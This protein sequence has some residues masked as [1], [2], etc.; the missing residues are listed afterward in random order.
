MAFVGPFGLIIFRH[1]I[2]AGAGIDA[3]S[4]QGCSFGFGDFCATFYSCRRFCFWLYFPCTNFRWRR[5]LAS[6]PVCKAFF[7]FVIC[8]ANHDCIWL[9]VSR[10]KPRYRAVEYLALHFCDV[11]S[12]FFHYPIRCLDARSICQKQMAIDRCTWSW[13]GSRKIAG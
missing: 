4:Y 3:E 10:R 11:F 6:R 2:K 9:S 12:G 5:K 8:M 13:A 1:S 7:W